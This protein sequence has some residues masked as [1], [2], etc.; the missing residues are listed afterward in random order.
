MKKYKLYVSTYRKLPKEVEY[1]YFNPTDSGYML[2]YHYEPIDGMKEIPTTNE[3]LLK[4]E[5]RRWLLG[6]KLTVNAETIN[7]SANDMNK[8]LSE[9]LT[10]FEKELKAQA[11]KEK[12]N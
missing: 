5:E 7:D 8:A 6:V 4:P 1:T 12:G 11:D 3:G 10:V 9:F 2:A